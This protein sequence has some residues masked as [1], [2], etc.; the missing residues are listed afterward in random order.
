MEDSAA[1]PAPAGLVLPA[2]CQAR[3]VREMLRDQVVPHLPPLRR[4]AAEHLA[5]QLSMSRILR[6]ELLH[7]LDALISLVESEAD[8]GTWMGWEADEAHSR[9]GWTTIWR[10]ERAIC[11]ATSAGELRALRTS[12]AAVL[13]WQNTLRLTARMTDSE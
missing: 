13:D 3:T 5:K 12:V 9:G 4:G 1:L 8:R 10:D 6:A 7:D 11:L 2:L